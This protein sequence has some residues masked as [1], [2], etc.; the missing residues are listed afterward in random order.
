M[1]P[2]T[3]LDTDVLVDHFRGL[4]EATSYIESLRV[5]QRST[6]DITVMELFEGA[7]NQ[8]ELNVQN[9]M[10]KNQDPHCKPRLSGPFGLQTTGWRSP[11]RR[12]FKSACER[13]ERLSN[14]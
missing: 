12:H 10:F 1:G 2:L 4:K 3:V 8:E 6:T 9:A 11:F 5:R 7:A 13:P 14:G